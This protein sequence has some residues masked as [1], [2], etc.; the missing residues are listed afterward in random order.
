MNGDQAPFDST[1]SSFR[2][3]GSIFSVLNLLVIAT[4]L[5]AHVLLA[6]YWGR[7]S[8]ILLVALGSGFL[9]HALV[10]IWIQA[11]T[12]RLTLRLITLLTIASISVNTVL[13]LVAAASNHEDSQYFAL[14]IVPILEG[15]FRFP[16]VGTL[17]VVGV[18]DFL[19]FFWVWQ[20]YRLH[21]SRGVNEYFEAGTVSL[22]YTL[23]GIIVWLLVHRLRQQEARLAFNLRE[24]SRTRERLLEEEKLAAVGRLSSAIAHEIRNPVAMIS[25][26]LGMT[27]RGGLDTHQR[28]EMFQIAAKEAL[29]LEKLTGDFLTYARPQPL[30]RCGTS[31]ADTL[32]YVA[33]ACKAFAS[34]RR[35]AL[36]VQIARELNVFMDS[37]KIQQALLNLVKNAI[38]ASPL[39]QSVT[40][41]GLE[42]GGRIHFDV[43]N[44]G[45]VISDKALRH[46]F[47]P[48]FTTKPGGTG[49]GL[50]IARN[51]ARAHGGDLVLTSNEPGRVCFSLELPLQDAGNTL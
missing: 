19:N 37:A 24:L 27:S 2:Q 51:I 36:D 41:R 7:L 18:A 22:I 25:S 32:Y 42:S 21:P 28:Q 17:V 9:F 10:L 16:I 39:G 35:I 46:I 15:A 12:N 5:L 48:F 47:E 8:P 20:Y 1:N 30:A 33:S 44:A 50:A 11:R 34:E 6:T 40:L 13:T 4:L 45:A 23:V 26:S 29:R 3:Q 14:M 49:L 31:A 38:E 43:Q